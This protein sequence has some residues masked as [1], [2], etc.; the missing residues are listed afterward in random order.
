MV[1][2]KNCLCFR[3]NTDISRNQVAEKLSQIIYRND[4]YAIM[5]NTRLYLQIGEIPSHQDRQMES[6]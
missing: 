1:N 3:I 2:D 6:I 5:P 4:E